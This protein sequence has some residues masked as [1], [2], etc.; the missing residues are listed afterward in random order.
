MTTKCYSLGEH[1]P[2]PKEELMK[3]CSIFGLGKMRIYG[4]QSW[5]YIFWINISG[6]NFGFFVHLD[7]FP[8]EGLVH[9][10]SLKMIIFILR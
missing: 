4:E 2:L 5:L 1:L 6:Y 3:Q 7:L 9:V 8:I 10:R